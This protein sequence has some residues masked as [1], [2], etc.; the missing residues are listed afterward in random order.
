[1]TWIAHGID[2]PFFWNFHWLICKWM[3]CTKKNSHDVD[4][5]VCKVWWIDPHY[6]K[7]KVYR[8]YIYHCPIIRENKRTSLTEFYLFVI[9]VFTQLVNKLSKLISLNKSFWIERKAISLDFSCDIYIQGTIKFWSTSTKKDSR[10]PNLTS[11]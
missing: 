9:F 8:K 3:W 1:M 5:K 11:F 2:S 10:K 4:S 6:E 7:I